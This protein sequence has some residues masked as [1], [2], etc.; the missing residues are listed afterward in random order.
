MGKANISRFCPLIYVPYTEFD[1]KNVLLFTVCTLLEKIKQS[2]RK[3]LHAAPP[4]FRPNYL[5]DLFT[6]V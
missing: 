3:R 6:L 4:P 2:E 1:K 5:Q